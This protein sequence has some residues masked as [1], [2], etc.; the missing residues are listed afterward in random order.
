MNYINPYFMIATVPALL[1][2]FA[3]HEYG[4]AWMA[5]RLG[6]PTPRSLGRLTL[7]PIAHL[8]FLGALMALFFLFGWAKPVLTNPSYYRG[9]KRK[10]H[11]MVAA[12]GPMMNFIVA[13]AVLFL[14][15]PVMYW[16]R[17][18]TWGQ[19]V[20]LVLYVTVLL[21]LGLGIFN[22]IPIPPLDGFSILR[23][24]LPWHM[25]NKLYFLEKYGF[26]ILL[27]LLLTNAASRIL[28]PLRSGIYYAYAS[29]I[30]VILKPFFG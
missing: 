25:A 21:N 6:D 12:A 14:M 2:G 29:I 28:I 16:L 22:L 1:I 9:D 26:V 24:V 20:N 19:Y 13:F 27:V 8:D 3:V 11:M 17:G 18:S 5:D 10:G 30:E 4:H 23:G 15:Y 7:N